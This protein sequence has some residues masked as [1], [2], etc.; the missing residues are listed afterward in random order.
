MGGQA[1]QASLSARLTAGAQGLGHDGA[2]FLAIEVTQVCNVLSI[3]GY[4]EGP[5]SPSHCFHG[6]PK[7]ATNELL[8]FLP[9]WYPGHRSSLVGVSLADF[10]VL[11]P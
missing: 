3:I 11:Q 2:G 9:H 8:S 6:W 4:R 10:L 5:Q 1:T 7:L